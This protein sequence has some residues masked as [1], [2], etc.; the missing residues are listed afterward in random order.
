MTNFLLIFFFV[1]VG[2]MSAQSLSQKISHKPTLHIALSAIFLSIQ[3]N[4]DSTNLVH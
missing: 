2:N 4:M 3:I 1:V